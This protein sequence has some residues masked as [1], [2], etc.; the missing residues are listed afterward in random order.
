MIKA[1]G[2]PNANLA[3]QFAGSGGRGLKPAF[4]TLDTLRGALSRKRN[5]TRQ[6]VIPARA[7]PQAGEPA[8]A[9][10]GKDA[11]LD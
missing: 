8:V 1:A 9:G 6:R 10:V 5:R 3:G 11:V 4:G 2:R 7:T